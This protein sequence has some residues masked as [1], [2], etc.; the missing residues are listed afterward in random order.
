MN[1]TLNTAGWVR[2]V[3]YIIS[4]LVGVA[5]VAANAIGYGDLA[6]L[7]GTLAG[8]GAAITGG[9]AV[10]NL[11]K[12][13]DQRLSGLDVG[14]VIAAIP[15]ITAA[16]KDYQPHAEPKPETDTTLPVYHGATSR[17]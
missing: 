5:A 3:I 13:T 10:Y 12:A 2:L 4:A 15:A 14:A 1:T 17:E 8:M 7:L 11:P 16:V 6:G 9:T